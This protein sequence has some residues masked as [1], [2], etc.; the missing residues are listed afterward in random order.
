MTECHLLKKTQLS[1][2]KFLTLWTLCTL[3]IDR[4]MQKFGIIT[5]DEIRF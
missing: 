4:M 1:T 2:T 5:A 3:S